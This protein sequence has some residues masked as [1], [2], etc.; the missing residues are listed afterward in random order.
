MTRIRAILLLSFLA[1][2]GCA[3]GVRTS[4]G[5]MP[6]Q[7]I[8]Q[9][10]E[11][12]QQAPLTIQMTNVSSVPILVSAATQDNTFPCGEIEPNATITV[13]LNELPT[14]VD[15][16][17]TAMSADAN[18]CTPTFSDVTLNENVDYSAADP[19]ATICWRPDV[20]ASGGGGYD[21]TNSGGNTTNSGGNTTNSGGNTTNTTNSGGNTT[22]SGGNTTNTTNS[23][24]NTTNSGGNTTN[25]GGNNSSNYGGNNSSNSGSNNYSNSGGNNSSNSGGNSTN[26][27]GNSTNSGSNNTTNNTTNSGS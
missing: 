16:S 17:A 10:W 26:S 14:F 24:G 7:P 5:P 22:S 12:A 9:P 27:G 3:P 4:E 23:G 13:T 15:C 20:Y 11:P 1:V 21:D 19:A 18:G 2:A 25:S 6:Q 8:A